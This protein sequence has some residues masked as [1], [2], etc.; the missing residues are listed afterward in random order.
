MD[1][2]PVELPR[3]IRLI[4]KEPLKKEEIKSWRNCVNESAPSGVVAVF[5]I[6]NDHGQLK[7]VYMIHTETK[8]KHCYSIPLTRDLSGDEVQKIVNCFAEKEPDIDFDIETNEVRL[9]R[10]EREG[11]SVNDAQHI[12]LCQAL[13]KSRHGKWMTDRL[14]DGWRYGVDFDPKEKTHPL[15]RSWDQLPDKFRK[16]DMESPQAIIDLINQQGFVI[17]SKDEFELLWNKARH[18]Y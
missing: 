8:K 9:E 17:I 11:I 13:A 6:T 10:D 3:Y 5:Q 18:R 16:P 12:A 15:L 7:S 4:T 2:Q 1:H 14:K